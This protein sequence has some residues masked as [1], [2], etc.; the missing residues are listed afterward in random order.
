MEKGGKKKK[1]I[2]GEIPNGSMELLQLGQMGK[3][4]K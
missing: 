4:G 3:M 1:I 2:N